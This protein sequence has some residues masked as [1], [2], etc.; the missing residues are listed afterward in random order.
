MTDQ[1]TRSVNKQALIDL[2]EKVEAGNDAI[3]QFMCVRMNPWDVW[4]HTI[5]AYRGSLDAAK[6]L[7]EAV[8]CAGDPQYGYMVGPQY[9]RIMH[10]SC[11]LVCDARSDNP[12]RAWL[13][14]ILKALIAKGG[15]ENA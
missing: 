12:A 9:A 13:I 15:E 10:P 14:A 8:L 3:V 11:G 6:A 7:H 2:L 4:G 1:Q 5:D